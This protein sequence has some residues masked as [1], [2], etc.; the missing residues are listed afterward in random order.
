M[1]TIPEPELTQDIPRT[2][3]PANEEFPGT[4]SDVD[5]RPPGER[6]DGWDPYE[7]WRTRIK[8]KQEP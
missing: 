3:S 8:A 1:N 4:V 7:V 5:K 6:A 2:V